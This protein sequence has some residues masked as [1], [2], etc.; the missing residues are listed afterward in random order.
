M[1]TS[2]LPGQPNQPESPVLLFHNGL[3]LGMLLA[4]LFEEH[5][6]EIGGPKVG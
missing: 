3:S 1:M 4:R 6:S 2:G 5:F